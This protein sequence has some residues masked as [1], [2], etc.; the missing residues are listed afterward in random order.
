[1]TTKRKN[2]IAIIVVA[3]IWGYVGLQMLDY[4][5]EE[6]NISVTGD[7]IESI[8]IGIEIKDT[9]QL[10]LNYADPFLRKSPKRLIDRSPVVTN[11]ITPRANQ[12]KEV[13]AVK[14]WPEIQY[15]GS[16]QSNT[17]LGMLTIGNRNHLVKEGDI[18]AGCKVEQ[19]TAHNIR[20]TF[21][22]TTKIFDK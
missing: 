22:G 7:K 15:F 13:P 8:N 20:L 1:M 6:E 11:S 12:S 5:E 19:I 14:T 10:Y 16:M 2:T 3:I 9:F 17:L 4:F 21:D 18:A